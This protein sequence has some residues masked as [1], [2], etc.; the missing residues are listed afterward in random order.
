M[1]ISNYPPAVMWGEFF[2]QSQ[3]DIALAGVPFLTGGDPDTSEYFSSKAIPVQG[4]G[5]MNTA[6]FSDPRID[7][8]L[9]E[10]A[11]SFSVEKRK[12][13]YFEIQR[14]LRDELTFF[15]IYQRAFVYGN[16]SKLNGNT[17]NPNTQINTWNIASWHWN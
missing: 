14:I 7:R 8:L 11:G 9:E 4:G 12:A 1:T 13:V 6:Q 10:G 17:P 15:P 3:F 16:D 2:F 5:G